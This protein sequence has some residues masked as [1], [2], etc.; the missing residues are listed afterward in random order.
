MFCEKK[1]VVRHSGTAVGDFKYE[2]SMAGRARANEIMKH[3]RYVGPAPVPLDQW[4]MSVHEQSMANE[5]PRLAD[6]KRAFQ[7]LLVPNSLLQQLGP[8]MTSGKGLFLFGTFD[9]SEVKQTDTQV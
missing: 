5:K 8:A 4:L 2:L 1:L 3:N 7:D 9:P 6:L